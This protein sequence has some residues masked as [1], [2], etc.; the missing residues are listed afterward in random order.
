MN[1]IVIVDKPEGFTSHDVVAKLRGIYRTRRIG[2]SGTLD[3][4]ATGVLP[5]FIG[6]ATRAVEFATGHDK[7][8]QARLLLGIE[9]D[10]QD[11]TG[12]VLRACDAKIS[13]GQLLAAIN[14]QI[15]EI[16]QIPPMYSAVKIGG[17]R[18]YQLARQGIEIERPARKITIYSIGVHR[19]DERIVD[20]TVRCSKGT[21]IRTLCAD[22]GTALGCGGTLAALRRIEAGMFSIQDA[23]SFDE[24]QQNPAAMLRPVDSMFGE[25]SKLIIDD[26]AAAQ[27]R[28]GALIS[29]DAPIGET[30]RVY[31]KNDRFLMLADVIAKGKG[32]YLKTIKSFFEV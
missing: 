1:G 27:V 15:G 20:L 17:K 8:Y 19:L 5:I 4:M 26:K 16:E 30:F 31:D 23:K 11:I 32:T 3:P 7:T 2:H 25:Y 12:R 14:S 18:L 9:T 6:R 10:S 29:T 22:I 21:Y 24:I 28:N 13:D